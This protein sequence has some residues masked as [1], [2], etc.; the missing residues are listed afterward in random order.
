MKD[1][2]MSFRHSKG[3]RP[4]SFLVV[5]L[6]VAQAS[7]QVLPP[8]QVDAMASR[9]VGVWSEFARPSAPPS[10]NRPTDD[11]SFSAISRGGPW[12][13][14]DWQP[15][16][17]PLQALM[18]QARAG[19]WGEV[20][21][22]IK[23]DNPNV[24][25]RD[26]DGATLLTLASRQ[27]QLDAV[28]EL[29]RRGADVDRRGLSGFTPL[30]A[31]AAAGHDLVVQELLRS[32]AEPERWSA[33]GQPPLHLAARA[34]QARVVRTLLAAGARPLG[35]NQAGRHAL[36]EAAMGGQMGTMAVLVE[37][38]V[39][40]AAPDEHGLNALHAAATHRHAAAV[41]WLRQRG[42]PVPHPLTQVLLDAMAEGVQP[43]P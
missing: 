3:L 4:L 11:A 27:G 33:Q 42:V 7:A 18:A 39:P 9:D 8:S 32:D 14:A 30:C 28:R 26:R 17:A 2:A 16:S 10:S 40:A 29:L 21:A 20:L 37:A 31:A 24:D 35:W 1:P 22:T 38:G 13:A 6:C 5:T 25:Q 12:T 43:A 36:A 41:D 34:G 19:Q 23:A 15:L